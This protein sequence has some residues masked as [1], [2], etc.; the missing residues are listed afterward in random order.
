MWMNKFFIISGKLSSPNPKSKINWQFGDER[1][2][3]LFLHLI[4]LSRVYH[5]MLGRRIMFLIFHWLRKKMRPGLIL[6]Y[7]D[8]E[9]E[10]KWLT[11]SSHCRCLTAVWWWWSPSSPA[12]SSACSWSWPMSS[13][14][15]AMC[16]SKTLLW[17]NNITLNKRYDLKGKKIDKAIFLNLKKK[18]ANLFR[19]IEQL[20]S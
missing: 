11:D 6:D 15:G 2:W 3:I 13:T 20:L 10:R 5:I 12:W 14:S 17:V 1:K 7:V 18:F 16:S 9:K 4:N 8:T 19:E